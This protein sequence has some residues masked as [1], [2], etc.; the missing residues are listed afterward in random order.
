MPNDAP[1]P[2]GMFRLARN[3][4]TYTA[5]VAIVVAVWSWA[6]WSF[7]FVKAAD[8]LRDKAGVEQRLGSIEGS[9]REISLGQLEA[10]E[11][12]LVQRVQDL[13]RELAK[14]KSTEPLQLILS[15]QRIEV[16]QSL[17]R[18]RRQLREKSNDARR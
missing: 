4:S 16:G 12:D 17:D 14:T 9:L 10:R 15:Q 18:V 6:G 11:S 8:Y 5:I 2:L 1:R 7:P 13:D 3:Y